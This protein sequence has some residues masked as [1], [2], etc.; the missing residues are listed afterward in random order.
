MAGGA[1]FS[2]G[3]AAASEG[4]AE[5]GRLEAGLSLLTGA[6]LAGE[7]AEVREAVLAIGG[8]A[9]ALAGGNGA[10]VADI[11]DAV[12]VRVG[13]QRIGGLGAV[14]LG[15]RMAVKV[16]VQ[17]PVR[18]GAGLARTARDLA[19][20]GGEAL[21]EA[22]A[23]QGLV[24]LPQFLQEGSLQGAVGEVRGHLA[25]QFL[26]LGVQ[27]AAALGGSLQQHPGE[28]RQEGVIQTLAE[29]QIQGLRGKGGLVA[30]RGHAQDQDQLPGRGKLGLGQGHAAQGQVD[31]PI[32][33]DLGQGIDLDLL[34]PGAQLKLSQGP[35]GHGSARRRPRQF[36]EPE[37]PGLNLDHPFK[38]Q[39]HLIGPQVVL[40]GGGGQRRLHIQGLVQGRHGHGA[41]AQHW[42]LLD[43][44][45]QP[46]HLLAVGLRRQVRVHGG[47]APVCSA[48][49]DQQDQHSGQPNA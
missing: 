36:V 49:P 22:G 5:L 43:H 12:V 8:Q 3:D 23:V 21:P 9:E 30:R 14:V 35:Q 27:G 28:A 29:G 45:L 39:F 41:A 17:H 32:G 16:G 25:K 20:P 7:V 24:G 2:V 38:G 48:G 15:V 47:R 40:R 31:D 34:D 10:G 13:E 46:R 4:A 44:P 11:S 33:A 18:V 6:V 42:A 19:K 37:A 1:G 26:D